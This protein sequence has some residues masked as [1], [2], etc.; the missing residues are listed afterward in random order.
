MDLVN[1]GIERL[2]MALN[3]INEDL[4]RLRRVLLA[5]YGRLGQ[6]RCVSCPQTRFEGIGEHTLLRLL[7][8]PNQVVHKVLEISKRVCNA[9][10]PVH[11][12]EGCIED[13]DN[14][15]EQV[16]SGALFSRI[17]HVSHNCPGDPSKNG[18]KDALPTSKIN[19]ISCSRSRRRAYSFA[20]NERSSYNHA[21]SSS[22]PSSSSESG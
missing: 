10:C 16:G 19:A 22:G 17:K 11:L 4:D 2:L 18:L 6:K 15:L 12:S 21:S 13:R 7:D 1:E 8:C 14:V 9:G 5:Y 20:S 3:Q